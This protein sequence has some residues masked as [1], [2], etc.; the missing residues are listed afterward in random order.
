MYHVRISNWKECS[1]FV[2]KG[3]LAIIKYHDFSSSINL[4]ILDFH[5][6]IHKFSDEIFVVQTYSF[7]TGFPSL[8]KNIKLNSYQDFYYYFHYNKKKNYYCVK[9]FT[10]FLWLDDSKP[11]DFYD[12]HEKISHDNLVSNIEILTNLSHL[13]VF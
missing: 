7:D 13:Q 6:T 8:I 3:W 10:L 4:I 12:S 1:N 11:K 2:P 5:I 9:N